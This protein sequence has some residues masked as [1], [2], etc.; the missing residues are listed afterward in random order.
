MGCDNNTGDNPS[1]EAAVEGKVNDF[2][3]Y[4]RHLE[5]G[6]AQELTLYQRDVMEGAIEQMATPEGT[7]G[8]EMEFA[9]TVT[10]DWDNILIYLSLL[11]T[12]NPQI[13]LN[14]GVDGV[15]DA[16]IGLT[17]DANIMQKLE[18]MAYSIDYEI[19]EIDVQEFDEVEKN[20]MWGVE[21]EGEAF[22]EVHINS[23]AMSPTYFQISLIKMDNEWYIVEPI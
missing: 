7:I 21:T 9:H 8:R 22:V 16:G 11:D 23:L 3:E 17:F 6:K 10:Q 13:E 2:F 12:F 14:I 20:D 1:S 5:L 19:N 18:L 4:I 15:L